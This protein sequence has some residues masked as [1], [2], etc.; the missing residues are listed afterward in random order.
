M[1]LEKIREF[2][3][4]ASAL[5]R[6]HAAPGALI[7]GMTC[8]SHRQINVGAIA[9]RNLR[10]NFSGRGVVTGESLSGRGIDTSSVD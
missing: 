7:E 3:D 8:R 10:E 4:E 5:R 6:C 1:L 2:P 9:F